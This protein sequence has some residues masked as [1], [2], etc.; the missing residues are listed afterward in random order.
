VDYLARTAWAAHE[1]MFHRRPPDG[2]GAQ[3]LPFLVSRIVYTGAGGWDAFDGELTFLLSPRVPFIS[4]TLGPDSQGARPIFHTKNEPLSSTGSSRLHV[5]SG[6]TT[7]SDRATLLRFGATA[8]VLAAIDAGE[9]PADVVAL[10]SPLGALGRFAE[11]PHCRRRVR[12]ARGPRCTAVDIQ[13]HYLGVVERRLGTGV[14]PA[15]AEAVWRLWA[16][17]LDDLDAG[18]AALAVS[19]DWAIKRRVFGHV[20]E[21]RGLS[22]EKVPALCRV[23]R[24]LRRRLSG[25]WHWRPLAGADLEAAIRCPPLVDRVA[26]RPLMRHLGLCWTELDALLDL[27]PRLLE[28]DMRFGQLGGAG[29]FDALDRAGCLAHRVPGIDRVDEALDQPPEGT[30][31]AVRGRVAR[32]FA[33]AQTPGRADWLH[34]EDH[35]SKRRLDLGD[36]FETEE[37]WSGPASPGPGTAR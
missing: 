34:V 13:R 32:R 4:E 21:Q 37:R 30:R 7:C 31:A 19:L 36:P 28:A 1:S 15:W 12:L 29:I 8:L 20:L 10:R 3:L 22:W 16:R 2:L 9:T 14:M 27:R 17:T 6:E 25:R 33:A 35:A 11:D 23:R 26:L 5:A 24:R 18:S